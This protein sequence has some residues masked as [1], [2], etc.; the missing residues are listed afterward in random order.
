MRRHQRNRDPY[1]TLEKFNEL[2][3]LMKSSV[4]PKGVTDNDFRKLFYS[5]QYNERFPAKESKSGRR[6]NFDATFLFNSAVKIKTVLQNETSG[7]IS[8]LRFITTYLP[9]L[10][11]PSDI[12]KA[13]SV[14]KI[15]LEEAK[16][17]ARIN[18]KNLGETVKRKPSE[19][20]KEI[21]DSH[22]KRQ[23]TQLEL[24][25]RVDER[26]NLTPKKEAEKLAANVALIDI[27]VDEL[28]EFNEFDTEH[29]LWEEIKGL[30]Y[31]MRE[32]DSSVIDNET[33]ENVLRDLDSI[34][35]KLLKFRKVENPD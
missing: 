10:Y 32:V 24:K 35:L 17:L 31:L 25:K 6:S 1:Q 11:Y 14:Y 21:I 29:L 19:I 30:V 27:N 34:K 26:L 4:Y 8:L 3:D 23:G 13:L 18:R 5:I 2:F 7:R 12:Q 22:I 9:I 33:T 20:R 16:I 15:N 28:L